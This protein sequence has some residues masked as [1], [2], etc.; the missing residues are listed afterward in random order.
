M[1]IHHTPDI[2]RDH[3]GIKSNLQKLSKAWSQSRFSAGKT[4]KVAATSPACRCCCS[5]FLFRKIKQDRGL[6]GFTS[7]GGPE[8]SYCPNIYIYIVNAGNDVEISRIKTLIS[9]IGNYGV[10]K[11]Y[12]FAFEDLHQAKHIPKVVRCLEEIEKLVTSVKFIPFFVFLFLVNLTKK[13]L[14]FSAKMQI[15]YTENK[16]TGQLIFSF[17]VSDQTCCFLV[18]LTKNKKTIVFL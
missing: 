16:Q 18:S 12:L 10:D 15:F 9:A 3:P 4:T 13:Q 17:L 5:H 11:K 7:R 1:I 8:R 6:V 2:C 14:S